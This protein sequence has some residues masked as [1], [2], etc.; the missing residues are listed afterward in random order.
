MQIAKLQISQKLLWS[1]T[2]SIQYVNDECWKI[3]GINK[4]TSNL[5]IWSETVWATSRPE[6]LENTINFEGWGLILAVYKKVYR[7]VN[8]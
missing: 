2:N 3:T 4:P 5:S 7:N 1:L 6:N 8:I